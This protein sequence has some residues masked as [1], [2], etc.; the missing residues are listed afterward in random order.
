[1]I[2][3]ILRKLIHVDDLLRYVLQLPVF[4]F[5]KSKHKL[6]WPSDRLKKPVATVLG[7]DQAWLVKMKYLLQNCRI[8]GSTV[9]F[10]KNHS[11]AMHS[12]KFAFCPPPPFKSKRHV[13]LSILLNKC[14]FA[15]GH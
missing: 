7:C 11:S 13:G 10:T 8:V 12:E 14:P 9:E 6:W 1:M 4:F 15:A 3:W 2:L 5:R